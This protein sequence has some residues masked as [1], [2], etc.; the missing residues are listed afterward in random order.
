MVNHEQCLGC[1]A[2]ASVCPQGAIKLKN[3]KAN[4]DTKKCV[5]CGMC[6]EICPALAIDIFKEKD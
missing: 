3:G 5:K 2:C 1:G 6:M 4:I